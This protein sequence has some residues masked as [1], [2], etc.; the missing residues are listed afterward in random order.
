MEVQVGAERL[1]HASSQ[2][3]NK[4]Q[5]NVFEKC[6]T[7]QDYKREKSFFKLGWVV[8]RNRKA[9][10]TTYFA[11]LNRIILRLYS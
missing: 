10:R 8:R 4:L 7:N 2:Q 11:I 5:H 6:L 3:C 9:A 1:S